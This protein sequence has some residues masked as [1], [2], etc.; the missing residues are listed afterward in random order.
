MGA[1][2]AVIVLTM[3]TFAEDRLK[4]LAALTEGVKLDEN[5]TSQPNVVQP[6]V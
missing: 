6:L 5:T 1:V 2:V 3:P 4:L